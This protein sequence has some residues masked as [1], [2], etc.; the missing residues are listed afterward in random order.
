MGFYVFDPKGY[1]LPYHP[2]KKWRGVASTDE[3]RSFTEKKRKFDKA[4]LKDD[5]KSATEEP[6]TLKPP[7]RFAGVTLASQI[8]S[9][10]V[11]SMAPETTLVEAWHFFI[12]HR[13]RHI[14]II[15]EGGKMI[16]ILSD[17]KL[18]SELNP[19]THELHEDAKKRTVGEIMEMHVLTSEPTTDISQIAKVF[20]RERIGGMPIVDQDHQLVGIITRSDIL[21]TVIKLDIFEIRA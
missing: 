17:R 11:V 15:S 16:G 19:L 13:F 1:R 9:H 2:E 10:P 21:R 18:L 5:V 7:P 3:A 8:M 12:E 6:S 14:P 4:L 20:I